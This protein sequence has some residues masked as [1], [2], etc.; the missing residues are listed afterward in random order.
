M[1]TPSEKLAE[2]LTLLRALQQDGVIAVRS[3]HLT[4]THRERLRH[5]GYLQEVMK[6]WYVATRPDEQLGASTA[7][8]ASFWPYCAA[9]LNDRF[10]QGWSLSPEQSLALHT[11][12]WTVPPQLLVRTPRGGNKPTGLLHGTS[13]FDVR[14]TLPEAGSN[15]TINNLRVFSL[16]ASLVNIGPG[17]FRANAT[18]VRA[19]LAM[20]GDASEVLSILLNRGRSVVAGRLAGAFRNVGRDKVADDILAGMKAVGYKVTEADPFE[21]V[22]TLRF[23]TRERSPYV[24]RMRLMWQ[25]MRGVVIESFP[26]PKLDEVDFD[27]YMRHVEE[28]YV[29]DAYHSLSIE[30]YRVS[31]DLIRKVRDGEWDPDNREE[32]REH[33]NA[34]AA[35]GYFEAFQA[36]KES[37]AKVLN[38]ADSGRVADDDH[39]KWY[40]ELFAPSVTAG[41]LSPGD[42]AG[43]RNGSV[44]IRQSMHVPP[45]REA[46]LDLM[47]V[48]FDLLRKEEHAAVRVVLGHFMFVYIHPYMDGNGRM[49]RFLMNVMMASG[50][51]PW[52]VIRVDRRGQYMTALEEASVHRNIEPFARFLGGLL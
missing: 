6:G 41:I 12:D 9:Y 33:R 50:G 47:P 26:D 21:E 37:V 8:Y 32:D 14:A 45:P 35:R 30:G 28:V 10:G 49:G 52:T 29:T 13:I 5:N 40:R 46:V 24:T 19:A 16:P 25:D 51:Y 3:R 39:R 17:M 7:W 15:D 20:I 42:L 43:Y 18:E 11:G 38:G 2:S 22:S 44:Y 36:V 48:F 23:D 1:A 27:R 31:E 34:L 4:R